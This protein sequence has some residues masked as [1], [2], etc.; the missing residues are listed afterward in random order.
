MQ[1]DALHKPPVILNRPLSSAPCEIGEVAWHPGSVG[2]RGTGRNSKEVERRLASAEFG[3]TKIE[4]RT[5]AKGHLLSPYGTPPYVPRYSSSFKSQQATR[6]RTKHY[7]PYTP[8]Y[9]DNN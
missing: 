1:F 8:S 9:P 7:Y 2:Q 6:S 4:D 5:D 3:V